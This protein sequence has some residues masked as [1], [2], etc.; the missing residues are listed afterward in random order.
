[1]MSSAYTHRTNLIGLCSPKH[2]HV[3]YK[4]CCPVDDGI[5]NFLIAVEEIGEIEGAHFKLP[6]AKET[7]HFFTDFKLS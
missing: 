5:V 4:I 1:M 3:E 2:Y 7:S 6:W